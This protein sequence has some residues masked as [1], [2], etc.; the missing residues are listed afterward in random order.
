MKKKIAMLLVA[1]MMVT[2]MA[3]CGSEKEAETTKTEEAG[4]NTKEEAED[5]VSEEKTE[6]DTDTAKTDDKKD[7]YDVALI[8]SL[9]GS[10]D[11]HSFTQG[12]WDGIKAF[13]DETG[14]TC[15]YYQATDESVNGYSNA[16]Q[17]A[18]DNGAEA[19]VCPG[20]NYEETVFEI[21]DQYPDVSFILVDGTPHNADYSE[22]KTADN[23][24]TCLFSE[25]Q[26]GFLAGYAIVKDGEKNLGFLGGMMM[27]AVIRYGYG[28]VQGADYAAKE[29]GLSKGDVTVKFGYTGNFDTSPENQTKAASWYK[30]GV[31]TIFSC[32]GNIVYSVTAAAEAADGDAH[33]IGVDVDQSSESETI[34]TSAMKMLSTAIYDELTKWNDGKFEGGENALLGVKE[35]AVGLPDDFSRFKT[36]TKEEYDA[37]YK[38]LVDDKDGLLSEMLSNT[39]EN[40]EEVT[41]DMVKD[42]LDIVE[43]EEIG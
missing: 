27:P 3:G 14:K 30:D 9:N 5:A 35:D 26:A 16:I 15:Q 42:K 19:I 34:V 24:Y 25:Q 32:G 8:I 43:V 2:S 10:I 21:Q 1:G 36:F 41:L 17:V 23:T 29:M 7:G 31:T 40:G 4:D 22:Y 6:N 11:D 33:V 39:D 20:Y 18:I 13:S 12:S 38:D 37:I 28:F